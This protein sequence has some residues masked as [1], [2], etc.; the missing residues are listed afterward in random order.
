MLT[1]EEENKAGPEKQGDNLVGT[2]NKEISPV[3][4][5]ASDSFK[6]SAKKKPK[7]SRKKN[8]DLNPDSAGINLNS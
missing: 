7:N 3:Q 1:D 8:S 2:E 4:A 5:L 6:S